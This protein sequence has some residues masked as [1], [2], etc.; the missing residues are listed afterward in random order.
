MLLFTNTAKKLDSRLSE[1]KNLLVGDLGL[2]TPGCRRANH[3]AMLSS[4]I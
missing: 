1:K 2:P 3:L 4:R